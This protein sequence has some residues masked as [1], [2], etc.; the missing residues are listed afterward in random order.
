MLRIGISEFR[1]NMNEVLQKVQQGEIVALTSRGAEIARLVP[2]EFAQ[3][4]A[5]QELE[6]LRKTAIVGDL[7]SPIDVVWESDQ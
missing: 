5:C 6:K 3:L 1:A 4:A 7:L 2:P